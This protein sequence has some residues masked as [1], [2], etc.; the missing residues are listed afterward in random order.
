MCEP[1]PEI[2]PKSTR[3]PETPSP[4]PSPCFPL[5]VPPGARTSGDSLFIYAPPGARMGCVPFGSTP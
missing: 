4:D 3:I 5:R 1:A 2:R